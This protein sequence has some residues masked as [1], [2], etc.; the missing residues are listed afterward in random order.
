MLVL[1]HV[2]CA[3]WAHTRTAITSAAPTHLCGHVL[4]HQ[5][6]GKLATSLPLDPLQ[7]SRH[8]QAIPARGQRRTRA[9]AWR[10]A[11]C[12]QQNRGSATD[13]TAHSLL[14]HVRAAAADGFPWR[15]EAP[16][17]CPGPSAARNLHCLQNC[18]CC[19]VAQLRGRRDCRAQ[20]L[21]LVLQVHIKLT[22]HETATGAGCSSK[23]FR[24]GAAFDPS[25]G[26]AFVA[27]FG[28]VE[29]PGGDRVYEVVGVFGHTASS[30]VGSCRC[31]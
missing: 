6:P 2:A 24:G 29:R 9:R 14:L 12:Q 30:I 3:A 15:A 20:G 19:C 8:L 13:S 4:D 11:R 5:D 7:G 23:R 16:A 22:Q 18:S 26:R 21:L 25:A 1:P 17:A 31:V 10:S 28:C 27:R